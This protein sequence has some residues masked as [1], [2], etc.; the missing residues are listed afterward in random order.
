MSRNR[1]PETRV[2]VVL[3]AELPEVTPGLARAL[4]A[5]LIELTEIPVLEL[6]G[7]EVDRDR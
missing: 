4:L 1:M 7:E 2:K 6:P 3:P 5:A